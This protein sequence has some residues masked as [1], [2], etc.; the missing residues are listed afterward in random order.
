MNV[1]LKIA[2]AQLN[3]TVGDI[4]RNSKK[5]IRAIQYAKNK[6]HADLVVFPELA[7]TGY[8]PED[9]LLR[10]QFIADA[11]NALKK[12]QK[13][14]AD[15]HV[16]L[17]CPTK[18][19]D[20]CFNSAICLYREKQL[21][22]YHKQKLPNYSVFDEKRYFSSGTKPVVL[23]I[24]GFQIALAICE[25]VWFE[26]VAKQAKKAGAECI[27][28]INA[29]PFSDKKFARRKEQ[30]EQRIKKI[31]IPI[32]YLNLIG[33]QD[34]LLFDGQSFVMDSRRRIVAQAK[35]FEEDWL[36]VE[37]D[38]N[39]KVIPKPLAL[40]LSPMESLY[41]A[42][43]LGVKDYVQKNQFSHVFIGL[44]GGIDSALTLAI[45]TDALGAKNVTAV[46][47]P[48]PFTA[49]MSVDDAISLSKA[50]HV[51]Y[52]IIPIH[53]IFETSLKTLHPVFSGLPEDIT[54]ENLQSRIRCNLLMALANK[55]NGL[56]LSTSNKSEIAV[57]YTTLYGDMSGAFC[58]LKDLYKTQVY[59]LSNYRNQISAV[60]PQ[61]I[62][63]RPP[64]AELAF[65]QTDQ[66]T[67]PPYEILD[68]ILYRFVEG[69]QSAALISK[70]LHLPIALVRKV[71]AMV[72]RSEYKRH[73]APP[74][75]RLTERGFDKDWRYPIVD[76]YW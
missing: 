18:P 16:I 45:A 23:S 37:I 51:V 41:R 44:S 69:N 8:P 5:I 48:S 34:E 62:I 70:T 6:L 71:I 68:K 19:K 12:I 29:S 54:E 75:P 72:K 60:I 3:F 47:M 4:S 17:G 33:G 22:C 20:T 11:E 56:M 35:A 14:S 49:S 61:R 36:T 39:K 55:T 1:K 76:R 63:D 50:L 27:L 9:L 42:L 66:D 24:K 15:I 40:P 52:Q 58:V 26:D 13:Y 46:I 21:A 59:A 30:L 10:P 64:S 65:D 57:G 73:Q 28:A 31:N 74:G 38:Q 43:V 32:F 25:D 67:L 53:D 2:L 7:L